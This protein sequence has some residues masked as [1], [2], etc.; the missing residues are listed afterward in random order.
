MEKDP[1]FII[2]CILTIFLFVIFFNDLL[3]ALKNIFKE[4]LKELPD[5]ECIMG[6]YIIA[7]GYKKRRKKK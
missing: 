2:N 4:F 3:Y 5:S 6:F 7:K 1:F